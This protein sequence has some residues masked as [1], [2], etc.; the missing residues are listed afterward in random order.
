MIS[1][2]QRSAVTF[3]VENFSTWHGNHYIVMVVMPQTTCHHPNPTGADQETRHLLSRHPPPWQGQGSNGSNGSNGGRLHQ[4]LTDLASRWSPWHRRTESAAALW[5]RAPFWAPRP[6]RSPRP[7]NMLKR[8]VNRR[9]SQAKRRRSKDI[10]NGC[11]A[12]HTAP[13]V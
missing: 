13:A 9:I 12:L 10:P 6:G 1:C 11:S 4:H 2:A 8:C 7:L 3:K 5:L